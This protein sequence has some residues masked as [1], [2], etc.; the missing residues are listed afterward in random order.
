M[1]ELRE[2]LA[3]AE[4]AVGG[5]CVIPGA[6][7]AE[8]MAKAGFDWLCIDAQHGLVGYGETLA[9]L[10]AVTGSG[11]PVLVRVPW[12]DPAWIMK[13]LDAGASGVI[14]PM[15]NSPAEAEQAAGACRYPPAGYR[16][17]GPTRASMYVEGFQPEPANESVVCAVMVETVA[18]LERLDE[19]AAV[20]G[21]DAVFMG[22]SD[23]A[24]S[25]G[26]APR[27]DDADHRR[28]LEAVPA[29]CKRQGVV[30]GIACGSLELLE[31]WRR[32]GYTMLAAPSDLVLLRQAAATLLD[33]ARA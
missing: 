30:A 21:V 13:A 1:P 27:A 31:R 9:M 32:A 4:G 10:Q 14:V 18:A 26:L 17:W 19:I 7:S 24:I 29:V 6:F 22:P 28:R 33:S 20:P 3:R 23:F 16:S 11:V 25:M 8:A 15:V 5:W 2:L 12:N